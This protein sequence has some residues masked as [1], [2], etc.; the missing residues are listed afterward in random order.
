MVGAQARQ[1]AAQTFHAFS[2]GLLRRQLPAS[3][4]SP[5]RNFAV[6]SPSESRKVVQMSLDL[7][8]VSADTMLKKALRE[9]DAKGLHRQIMALKQ[10]GVA[11]GDISN[12]VLNMVYE[13]YVAAL[14]QANMLDF[15]DLINYSVNLL[16]GKAGCLQKEQERFTHVLVDEFQDTTSKQMQII[17]ML[18]R[19]HGRV[20][21]VGDDDQSIYGWRGCSG[22]FERF[23]TMFPGHGLALL[24]NNY[25]SSG[26]IV[27]ASAT[28]IAKNQHRR[29]KKLGT[30]NE[31]GEQIEVV[32][33]RTVL[34]EAA[35]VSDSIKRLKEDGVKLSQI[36]VLHRTNYVGA[37]ARGHLKKC[38]IKYKQ[39]DGIG[40]NKAE[41]S[42]KRISNSGQA[43]KVLVLLKLLTNSESDVAWKEVVTTMSKSLT[44]RDPLVSQIIKVATA[45]KCSHSQAA[46][47]LHSANTGFSQVSTDQLMSLQQTDIKQLNCVLRTIDKFIE[48]ISSCSSVKAIIM[49]L[50][51]GIAN[52]VGKAGERRFAHDFTVKQL[53]A[54]GEEF[55]RVGGAQQRG[56]SDARVDVLGPAQAKRQRKTT[57]GFK[58]GRSF[59]EYVAQLEADEAPMPGAENA[60]PKPKY[61]GKDEDEKNNF[62]T[63]STVHR[64]KGLEWDYVFLVRMNQGIFPLMRAEGEEE[65]R[66]A[67]VAMSRARKKLF[68]SY[69]ETEDDRDASGA[70]TPSAYLADIP[71]SLR[72][73]KTRESVKQLKGDGASS[74]FGTGAMPAPAAKA[75]SK[76]GASPLESRPRASRRVRGSSGCRS[77]TLTPST[78]DAKVPRGASLL[79]F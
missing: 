73:N 41:I 42:A 5:T 57:S 54:S 59:V 34:C 51:D 18:V 1:V 45:R 50:V 35:H 13:H 12:P 28:V 4:P 63:V 53:I 44:L 48:D 3:G 2:L 58:L 38:D 10:D 60:V 64:A 76:A 78:G 31:M 24:T 8:K 16:K 20:T 43:Q 14:A 56:G 32:A 17:E 7:V 68:I 77:H 22:S 72:V 9:E 23:E 71:K 39:H 65:R 74:A 46:R 47:T 52:A 30:K 26:T 15:S 62:V 36:A 61:A 19:Q 33:C 21:V 69:A 25:R 29:D 27:A 67:Y 6:C 40:S 11:A 49:R 75:R 37:A 70:Y 55:E 66:L 79:L